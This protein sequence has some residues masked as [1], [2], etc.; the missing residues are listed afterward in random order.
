MLPTVSPKI[1][2]IKMCHSA[3]I[4]SQIFYIAIIYQWS[5]P[6][7][8]RKGQKKEKETF[9]KILKN[10]SSLMIVGGYKLGITPNYD[11]PNDI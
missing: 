11:D 1:R 7:D 4:M 5:M 2:N 6:K 10:Q 8:S 3:K 9:S